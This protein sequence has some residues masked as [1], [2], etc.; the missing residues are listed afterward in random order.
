MM[1]SEP[2]ESPGSALDRHL[3]HGVDARNISS[4]L[5]DW[6]KQDADAAIAWFE[7]RRDSGK[8]LSKGVADQPEARLVVQ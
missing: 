1:T 6:A 3:E 5:R 4:R 8:L 7:S 2:D